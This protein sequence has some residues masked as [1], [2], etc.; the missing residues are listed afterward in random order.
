[1]FVPI[2]FV[3]SRIENALFVRIRVYL[4]NELIKITTAAVI[5]FIV[6][7][8][9]RVRVCSRRTR[10]YGERVTLT[11]FATFIKRREISIY[12]YVLPETLKLV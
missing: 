9:M 5:I 2:R 3:Y 8:R 11:R 1:M 6:F 10:G 12:Y 4:L 7:I